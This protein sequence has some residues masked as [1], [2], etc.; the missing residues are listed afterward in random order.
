VSKC[1]D[2]GSSEVVLASG[3]IVC[4][5]CD[6]PREPKT[7]SPPVSICSPTPFKPIKVLAFGCSE[8]VTALVADPESVQGL[9]GGPMPFVA[10]HDGLTPSC[11]GELRALIEYPWNG[12]TERVP[13]VAL[14]DVDDWRASVDRA[15]EMLA[16]D[17]ASEIVTQAKPRT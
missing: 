5:H 1:P 3:V 4:L 17:S 16:D 10:M 8:C 9:A 13:L 15:A 11:K 7:N 12:K 2:C 6:D 14:Y